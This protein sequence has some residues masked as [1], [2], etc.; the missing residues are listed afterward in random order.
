MTGLGLVGLSSALLSSD[1]GPSDLVNVVDF[2]AD[3][4]GRFDSAPALNSAVRFVSRIGGGTVYMPAGT[5]SLRSNHSPSVGKSAALWLRGS[6]VKLRG[7][8]DGTSLITEGLDYFALVGSV[9]NNSQTR[10]VLEAKA[11]EI[12]ASIWPVEKGSTTI[13]CRNTPDARHFPPNTHV[14]IRTGNTASSSDY[15][16]APDAEQSIV[17]END[18]AT[19]LLKLYRPLIKS[20]SLEYFRN[21]AAREPFFSTTTPRPTPWPA[22]LAV[23][24]VRPDRNLEILDMRIRHIGPRAC[25]G[26]GKWVDGITFA[27]LDV[28]CDSSFQS[29]SAHRGL[30]AHHNKIHITGKSSAVPSPYFF[31]TAW[32]STDAVV[33]YNQCSAGAGVIA[34]MHVHEGSARGIW[35]DNIVLNQPRQ[36]L[37]SRAVYTIRAR[38]YD[39]TIQAEELV[40]TSVSRGGAFIRLDQSV[41]GDVRI[42][43]VVGRGVADRGVVRAGAPNVV[44]HGGQFADV[45]ITGLD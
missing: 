10:S 30:R 26:G 1:S 35:H 32:G 2:G 15:L 41:K 33:G 3:P 4:T 12:D 22:P 23:R 25:F 16:G 5:Y 37:G 18:P 24:K 39:I 11:S 8:G 21:R 40:N 42:I 9:Q 34:R 43:D 38:A 20:Y 36:S 29:M 7:D 28:V 31:S 13:T 19:G 27:G 6:N 17:V 44:T 14:L 45:G